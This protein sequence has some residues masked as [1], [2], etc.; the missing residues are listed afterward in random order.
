[1]KHWNA[2]VVEMLQYHSETLGAALDTKQAVSLETGQT[3][4]GAKCPCRFSSIQVIVTQG[5]ISACN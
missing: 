4:S 1:M 5:E 3:L 2:V